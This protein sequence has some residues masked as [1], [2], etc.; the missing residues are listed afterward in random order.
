MSGFEALI[1]ALGIDEDAKKTTRKK[2]KRALRAF[3]VCAID[4]KVWFL[5]T[6]KKGKNEYKTGVAMAKENPLV[7]L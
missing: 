6:T 3:G 5:A 1:K 2:T 7:P 4:V